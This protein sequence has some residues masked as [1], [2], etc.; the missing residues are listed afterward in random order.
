[1]HKKILFLFLTFS[2]LIK[3]DLPFYKGDLFYGINGNAKGSKSNQVS[4]SFWETSHLMQ[5][6]PNAH[7]LKAK[8]KIQNYNDVHENNNYKIELEDSYQ[9]NPSWIIGLSSAWQNYHGNVVTRST[10]KVD[11][12]LVKLFANKNIEITSSS[13][14][15]F[16]LASAFQNFSD[17]SRKDP[18]LDF[19]IGYYHENDKLE[20]GP[21]INFEFNKS[22]D[23]N[24]YNFNI[25][26]GF[27][28]KWKYSDE[29]N[30][31][32]NVYYTWT[33]YQKVYLSNSSDKE[34]V[35]YLAS[36]LQANQKLT[37]NITAIIKYNYQLSHSNNNSND[38]DIHMGLVGMSFT[39]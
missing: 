38:Y 7:H 35:G 21:E 18:L 8:L 31:N 28:S 22:N 36:S 19:A 14:L 16:Q 39:Y 9:L 2:P 20:F 34:N 23:K 37:K 33:K 4:D 27:Y 15:Y 1:M 3:A 5:A 13:S 10:S 6:K 12:W 11:N 29:L 17:I 30:F 24:N 32:L 25:T 26:P